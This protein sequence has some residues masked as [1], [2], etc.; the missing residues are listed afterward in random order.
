MSQRKLIDLNLLTAYDDKIKQ[1]I[2]EG[3]TFTP[4]L[5]E[6]VIEVGGIKIGDTISE[7]SSVSDILNQILFPYTQPT[8]GALT[9]TLSETPASGNL[10]KV[11]TTVKVTNA[12]IP[13]TKRSCNVC[14]VEFGTNH[15]GVLTADSKDLTAGTSNYSATLNYS[16]STTTTFTATVYDM[17]DG[18]P[19]E[20]G[21]K[22][23]IYTF[24]HPYRY[25]V[26][27]NGINSINATVILDNDTE[28]V[29]TKGAQTC[30]F[31]VQNEYMFFAYPES[32]GVLK[33]DKAIDS[34]G[35][36]YTWDKK[37]ITIN[38]V[39]HYVY[40]SKTPASGKYTFTFKY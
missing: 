22:S 8:L 16:M 30:T 13:V 27:T 39:N 31:D 28:L 6:A 36:E 3:D 24:V 14:E 25:G 17:K 9:L 5:N 40:V 29:K 19:T 34:N 20:A 7:N 15:N 32:Y 11:G 1:V 33:N 26:L 23:V 18:S 4:N 35:F 12:S 2:N 10:F 21:S 38:G 37:I